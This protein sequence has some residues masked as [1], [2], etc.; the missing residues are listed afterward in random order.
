MNAD[1]ILIHVS[2]E[3]FHTIIAALRYYQVKGMGNPVFRSD[4]I[5]D[6]ATNGGEVTSLDDDDIDELIERIN[7]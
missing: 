3:E 5:H 1:H 2:P 6:L 7:E 4:G